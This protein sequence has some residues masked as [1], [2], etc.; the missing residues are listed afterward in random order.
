MPKVLV[1]SRSFAQIVSIGEE[2]LREAGFEVCLIGPEERPLDEMKMKAIVAREDPEAIV[3]GTEPLTAHVFSAAKELRIVIK[4]GV[5]VDNIDLS[6]ATASGVVVANAPGTNTESVADWVIG[7]MLVLLR[8]FC[9]ANRSI[10]EGRWERSRFLGHDLGAKTVGVIGTGRIG[11]AVVKRLRPFEPKVLAYDVVEN[12]DLT[13]MGAVRYTTLE[14][15]LEESDLVS[16]HVPLTE[17]TRNMIGAAELA[18][19]KRSAYLINGARA[20]LVDE[21]ALYEALQARHLA[22]AA[23]D[24]LATKPPQASLLAGL[25]NVFVTP[26]IAA[27]TTEAME[28]MDRMCAETIVDAFK[29]KQL[30]NVLN[31]VVFELD[32]D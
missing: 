8:G 7:T 20:G 22:G 14:E 28:R 13:A 19:M 9:A 24:M 5:G 32:N 11:I 12:P 17:E 2:I 15:L 1:S 31:P 29:G 4:H 23:L 10:R 30:Q 21:A 25:D 18:R 3:S 6:A 27:V 26:H 16:L